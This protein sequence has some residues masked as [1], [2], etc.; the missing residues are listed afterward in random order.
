MGEYK[1][2][3]KYFNKQKKSKAKNG[4]KEVE[5]PTRSMIL[6]FINRT[7]I[8]GI[9]LLSVLC[10][11]KMNPDT[12]KQVYQ[13]VYGTNFSFASFQKWYQKYFG[14]LFPEE[15]TKNIGKDQMVFQESFVYQKKENIENGVRVSVGKGYLMP[16]LESGLV[17]FMGEKEDLGETLIIQQV[18]GVDAW[19]VGL[20]LKDL[21]LYDYVEKGSLLGETREKTLDLY[22]QKEGAFVDYQ[23]Y[24]S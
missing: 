4:L 3:E 9:L 24:I 10:M 13:T 21:K 18:N 19:Y 22:F 23:N 16:T 8:S 5:N 12:K 20:T 7:L 15:I 11:I 1:S 2:V 17:V 14:N 6:G